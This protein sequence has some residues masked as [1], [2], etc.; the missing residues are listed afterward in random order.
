MLHDS[1]SNKA[2]IIAQKKRYQKQQRPCVQMPF[3]VSF[4]DMCG[5]VISKT[6]LY[7]YK[8]TFGIWT[9]AAWCGVLQRFW[10]SPNPFLSTTRCPRFFFPVATNN[11]PADFPA[12]AAWGWAWL[13][14]WGAPFTKKVWN[15]I[16][17]GSSKT[18]VA[19]NTLLYLSLG[20]STPGFFLDSPN[21]FEF[22]WCFATFVVL[23]SSKRTVAIV[24]FVYI[25]V[26][27]LPHLVFI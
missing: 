7:I 14:R 25:Q 17:P 15:Q 11:S 23:G 5:C 21:I 9:F 18:S 16:S 10:Y 13:I 19:S 12:A 1:C 27:D 20:S 3:A 4:I 2:S 26:W 24:T 22:E 8:S 6:C